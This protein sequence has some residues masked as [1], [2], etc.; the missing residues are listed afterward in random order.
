MTFYRKQQATSNAWRLSD[1]DFNGW[2]K[3]VKRESS[4]TVERSPVPEEKEMHKTSTGERRFRLENLSLWLLSFLIEIFYKRQER[5]SKADTL[6]SS[7]TRRGRPWP[8]P[9]REIHDKNKFDCQVKKFQ[10]YIFSPF[11][12]RAV[13][14]LCNKEAKRERQVESWWNSTRLIG[15]GRAMI[16]TG[17]GP[18]AARED[19]SLLH[20]IALFYI[21]K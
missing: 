21:F 17:T 13:S 8:T 1:S 2:R 12:A 10:P 4:R 20:S 11:F 9:D 5:S 18:Q 7:Y 3:K 16:T 6:C 19:V 14:A 15:T